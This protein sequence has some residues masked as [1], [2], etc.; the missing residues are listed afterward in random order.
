MSLTG[1]LS[2]IPSS[3][4]VQRAARRYDATAYALSAKLI[5]INPD[6]YTLFNYRKEIVLDMMD[7]E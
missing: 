5:E 4:L 3:V 1:V 2:L 7:K 6:F